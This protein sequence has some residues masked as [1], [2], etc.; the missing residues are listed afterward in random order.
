MLIR[1]KPLK[2]ILNFLYLD[3]MWVIR[4]SNSA[5]KN[6]KLIYTVFFFFFD[7]NRFKIEV[8]TIL[9]F[10]RYITRILKIIF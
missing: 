6:Y 10:F 2:Q 3:I 5:I 4:P 7:L 8:E 1:E 9:N